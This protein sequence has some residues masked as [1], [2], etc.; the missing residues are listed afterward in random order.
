MESNPLPIK[1]KKIRGLETAWIEC[2][3]KNQDCPVLLF[4]HGC[5]DT[6]HTWIDQIEHFKKDYQI[7]APFARGVQPS[8]ASHQAHRYS[9]DSIVLDCLEILRSVEGCRKKTSRCCRS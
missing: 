4:F 6:P 5:P 3:N 8:A 2:G 1:K 9:L 7:I